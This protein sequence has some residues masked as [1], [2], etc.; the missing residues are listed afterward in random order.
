MDTLSHF[1]RERIPERVVHAKGAG[2]YSTTERCTVK[3]LIRTL[4]GQKK[5]YRLVRSPDFRGYVMYTNRV[6]RTVKSVLFIEVPYF[7]VLNKK[8]NCTEMYMYSGILYS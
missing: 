2:K 3:P 1:D 6:R 4:L 7:S 5:L 8:F